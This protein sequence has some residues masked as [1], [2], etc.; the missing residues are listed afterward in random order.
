MASIDKLNTVLERLEVAAQKLEKMSSGDSTIQRL[1]QAALRLEKL[2]GSQTATASVS[3]ASVTAFDALISGPELTTYRGLSATIGGVVNEQAILVDKALQA[4]RDLIDLAS[5]TKKPAD[6]IGP[7]NGAIN[8]IVAIK[9]KNRPSPLFSHLSAVA[10]GI[11][12]L[13]WVVVSVY[14]LYIASSCSIH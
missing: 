8:A 10:D 6:F 1:E 2:S 7:L 5:R 14:L 12:A 13:G 11:G 4:Q 3:N 9:D